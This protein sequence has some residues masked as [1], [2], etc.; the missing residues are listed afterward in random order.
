MNWRTVVP[1]GAQEPHQLSGALGSYICSEMLCQRYEEQP[2]S[3]KN[4]QQNSSILCESHGWNLLPSDEQPGNP[5][6]AMVSG[7][8]HNSHHRASPRGGQRCGRRRVQD[9][10]IVCGVEATPGSVTTDNGDPWQMQCGS[11]CNTA[12]CTVGAVRELEA[13]PQCSGNGCTAITMGQ[14]GRLC[15]SPILS[16]WQMSKEDQRGQGITNS[17]SP[18]VEGSA[19]VSGTAG[20]ANR[21]P[22]DSSRQSNAVDRPIQQATFPSRSRTDATSR[23]EVIRHKQQAEG[24]SR[25]ASQLLAAG[26]SKGT[27]TTYQSAWR[28][29]DSWCSQRQIDPLS[30]AIQHFLE[31]LTSL[32][33]EGL[34]YR[35]VNTIRSA[36]S[37]THIEGTPIG[38]HPLVSRLLKGVYNMWPPQPRY[39][40]T[41][42]VDVV[43]RHL[44]SLGE[45]ETLARPRSWSC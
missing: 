24:I 35:T 34:Q 14:V 29:W 21:F 44:Q 15:I 11:L 39:S 1:A 26:W 27:N 30:C 5:D 33:Q 32:F 6:L 23:L 22:S 4:G 37:M 8:E 7:K 25:E 17:D 28:R 12:E 3:S 40:A 36:V 2:C 10:P 20:T 38:Q 31:F 42:D 18:S 9:D 45:N 19:V 16:N 43:I 13:R 41:W